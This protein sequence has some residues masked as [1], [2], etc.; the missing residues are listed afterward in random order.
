MRVFLDNRDLGVI[1]GSVGDCLNL[2]RRETESANRI[3]VEVRIDDQVLSADQLEPADLAAIAGAEARFVSVDA[4]T[5][6]TETFNDA[7]T[8]LDSLAARQRDVADKLQMGQTTDAL[9]ALREVIDGWEKIQLCVDQGTELAGLDLDEIRRDSPPVDEAINSLT[10]RLRELMAAVKES[11]WVGLSD[12][13]G[14]DMGPVAEQ[15][16]SL[17]HELGRRVESA[18]GGE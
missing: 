9:E 5:F 3:L 6:V 16:R 12:C 10:A 18:R 2:A 7:A 1:D 13:L 15:W 17:L 14:Y 11:D 8:A 4:A